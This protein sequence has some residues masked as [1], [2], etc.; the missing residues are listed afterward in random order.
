MSC[1]YPLHSRSAADRL[2]ASGTLYTDRRRETRQTNRLVEE[3]DAGCRDEIATRKN[4]VT[5]PSKNLIQTYCHRV[6]SF[7]IRNNPSGGFLLFGFSC[8][9]NDFLIIQKSTIR[10]WDNVPFIYSV[11]VNVC[12]FIYP[13]FLPSNIP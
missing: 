9:L 5:C 7:S 12:F 13:A 3:V 4:D 11:L 2:R 6:P 8:T 1:L 10:E